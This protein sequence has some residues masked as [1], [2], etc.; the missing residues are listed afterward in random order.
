M[1]YIEKKMSSKYAVEH[2]DSQQAAALEAE[3]AARSDS[4]F[5][6]QMQIRGATLGKLHEVDLG[7][8]IKLKN[9][10]RTEEATR[11]L[12]G[13]EPLPEED[14]TGKKRRGKRRRRNSQDIQRDKLVEE[15]LKETRC[16]TTAARKQAQVLTLE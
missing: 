13:K 1:E 15:V 11:R 6:S 5:N 7:E 9:I 16:K 12:E 4:R 2:Q 3:K 8:E 14:D 10:Q